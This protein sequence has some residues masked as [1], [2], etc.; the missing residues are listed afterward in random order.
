MNP[1]YSKNVAGM[2]TNVKRI[3]ANLCFFLVYIPVSFFGLAIKITSLNIGR[4][5]LY[6]AIIPRARMGSESIAHEAE[7][8]MGY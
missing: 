5:Q 1:T 6:L 3:L 4:A 8:R 7:G 2:P